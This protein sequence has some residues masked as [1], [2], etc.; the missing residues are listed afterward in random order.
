MGILLLVLQGTVVVYVQVGLCIGY[1]G[2]ARGSCCNLYVVYINPDLGGVN[3]LYPLRAMPV[4]C[5]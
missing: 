1:E 5:C 3:S 4:D 2:G